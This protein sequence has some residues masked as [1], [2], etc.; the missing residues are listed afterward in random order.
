MTA[1]AQKLAAATPQLAD[2]RLFRE[3]CYIDGRWTDADSGAVIEVTNPARGEV[4]GTIPKMGAAETRRAIAAAEKA[5][6][7]W[8]KLLAQARAHILPKWFDLIPE[9][10]AEPARP[11]TPNT[12]TRWGG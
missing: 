2:P 6:P 11:L 7:A 3:Q 1:Q 5:W 9:N 8:R 12:D 10:Q 4:L